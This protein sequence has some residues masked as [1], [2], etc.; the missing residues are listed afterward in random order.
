[1]RTLEGISAG[2]VKG[3]TAENVARFFD[4]FEYELRTVNHPVHRIFDVD[5]AGITTV[6]HRHSKDVSMKARKERPV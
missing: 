3:C 2:R 1:M 4:I 6:Q 5:E